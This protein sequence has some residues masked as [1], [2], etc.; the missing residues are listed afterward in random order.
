MVFEVFNY[1]L[2]VDVDMLVIFNDNDML[3]LYNVGGFFNYLVKIFFSCIYSS[4]CEGSKKVFLCL[5]G[6]WEIVWCIEEYVKGMLVFGILFEEFGWNYIGLIDGYDLLILVVILCNMCDMKGLQFFYVVI[7]KGK[8][9]VLVELDLIGYYVIIKLEV[10]GSVLKKIGG[11][12][13]FSVFGQWLCDMVVQDVCLFGIILVMKE[14]FDLVVFSECYLECYFDVVIVEQYVVILVVG[15]VCEGMKLVVVIYLI[16]FQCVYDQL[17]YDVVV[18]YFDVLFVI[19]CVGL[20]GEDGLI[21]VGSFDIFYLCCIFG[22]LVM[23]FSD[24]DE[25][26][27]LFII[28]YLFDGLV[29]VCYLCGSGFNYLIDLDL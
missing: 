18:Q 7:K 17:I 4:M 12:K 13:Y 2:E 28:G 10:F 5:F 22:M 8:G 24:E 9:F 27:K 21:Y 6:V 3:I 25:L 19:D 16:F 15:M 29:V 14:G 1:V 20:V 23:I 26:C 11:F